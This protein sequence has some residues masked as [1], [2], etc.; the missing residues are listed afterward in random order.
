MEREKRQYTI[1]LKKGRAL[2]RE[3]IILLQLWEPGTGSLQLTDTAVKNGVLGKATSIRVKDIVSR[4]F[5]KRYVNDNDEPAKYLKYLSSIQWPME[6]LS[7]LFFLYTARSDMA[8]YDF[9]TEVYW[10]KYHAGL[11]EI[12]KGDSLMFLKEAA[13]KGYMKNP[14]S[15]YSIDTTARGI[16]GCLTGFKLL[17][18]EKAGVRQILPFSISKNTVNY[19]AHEMHFSGFSDNTIMQYPGWG[20]FGLQPYS[21][22]EELKS[23]S[24]D[25]HFIVQ[26]SGELLKINWKYKNME[27]FIHAITR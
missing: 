24:F 14:W 1:N 26:F 25:G 3:T 8:L 27:E 20:L 2:I 21:V 11:E 7:H 17:G 6:E 13:Q 22:L 16:L 15:D 12:K 19:M 5:Y 4:F 18:P 10:P 9:I 23:V